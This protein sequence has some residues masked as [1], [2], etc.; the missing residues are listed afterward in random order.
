M[1]FEMIKRL[2]I[3]KDQFYVIFGAHL[4]IHHKHRPGVGPPAAAMEELVDEALKDS[5]ISNTP[6]SMS[7]HW[8]AVSRSD[9]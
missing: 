9:S 1:I 4:G 8:A 7:L 3:T 2:L 5:F 6:P